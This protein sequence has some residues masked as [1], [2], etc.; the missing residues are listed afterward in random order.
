MTNFNIFT[1]KISKH[2]RDYEATA[3]ELLRN[4]NEFANFECFVQK[5]KVKFIML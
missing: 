3:F 2:H 4:V 5:V 1:T